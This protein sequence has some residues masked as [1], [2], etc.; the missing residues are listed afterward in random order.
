MFGRSRTGPKVW[1]G[2]FFHQADEVDNTCPAVFDVCE[3]LIALAQFCHVERITSASD[4]LECLVTLAQ[5]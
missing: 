2:S 3:G 5:I 4:A 1:R